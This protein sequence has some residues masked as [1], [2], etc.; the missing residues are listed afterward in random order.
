MIEVGGVSGW[1]GL[2]VSVSVVN[3]FVHTYNH[4]DP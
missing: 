3:G 2:R 4:S 1:M